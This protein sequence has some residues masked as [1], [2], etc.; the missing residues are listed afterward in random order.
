MDYTS[1][2]DF[3]TKEQLCKHGEIN[4]ELVREKGLSPI[5]RMIRL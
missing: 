1:S 4:S 3:S 5:N 2:R